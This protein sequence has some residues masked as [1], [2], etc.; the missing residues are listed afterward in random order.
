MQTTL[1]RNE[2]QQINATWLHSEQSHSFSQNFNSRFGSVSNKSH[3]K[4]RTRILLNGSKFQIPVQDFDVSISPNKVEMRSQPKG[5]FPKIEFIA[6]LNSPDV[7]IGIGLSDSRTVEGQILYTRL[8]F[9]INESKSIVL[10]NQSG[11]PLEI[12]IGQGF[13]IDLKQ[14]EYRAKLF[15]KLSFIEK[16]FNTKFYLP[17]LISEN[18]VRILEVIYRGLTEGEFLT[19]VGDSIEIS[20]FQLEMDTLRKPPFSEHGKFTYKIESEEIALFGKYLSVG[21]ISVDIEKSGI[22]NPRIIRN[23]KDGDIIPQIRL[24]VFDFQ[25]KHR[26][27]KYASKEKLLRN[28][29]KLEQFKKELKSEES[30]ILVDLIDEPLSEIFKGS[31]IKIVEGLLQY[32]NFPDRFSVLE[33]K[34]KDNQWQVPIALT[35]SKHEPIW[36]ADAFVDV[37]T[38]KVEMKISFDELLKKGKK[39]AKE[40]FSIA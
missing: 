38:G 2:S 17:S 13:R 4:I 31:A 34:Q 16:F 30:D 12:A 22:A 23:L 21:K 32:Y 11:N 28:N 39:K 35:Y 5:S 33:P 3:F 18:E 19:A 20:N 29:Q 8:L 9:A 15:R 10:P 25:I 14:M 6:N 27:E 26:F 7:E 37:K 24:S 36:L 1:S 40:I